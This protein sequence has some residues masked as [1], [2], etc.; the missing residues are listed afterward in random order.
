[1]GSR[2]KKPERGVLFPTDG[3]SR[4]TQKAGKAIL[5]AAI[6]GAGIADASVRDEAEKLASKCEREKNWRFGYVTH[7]INMVKISA[8]SPAAALGVA[9]AGIGAMHERFEFVETEGQPPVPFQQYM[10]APAEPFQTVVIEGTGQVQTELKVPYK[11][12]TLAG[13]A[14]RAQLN[15]WAEYGTIEPDAAR[16]LVDL[17]QGPV[18]LQGQVYVLIGAGSAMGPL[19]ALL[20]HGATVVAVDI[21]GAWGERPQAMWRRLV[22]T[23]RAS[24]GRLV[25]P[26]SGTPRSGSDEEVCALAGCNLIE[27][28]ARILA[29]L[30]G[31]EPGKRLVVG[32]YTYLDGDMHVKLSL[33][34]D[35]IMEGLCAT[36]ADTALAFLCTPTDVHLIP[37]EA[38]RAAKA[39][40]AFTVYTPLELLIRALS[41]GKSLVPNALKP[42]TTSEGGKLP[43][44]DGLSV[45]Q[46]P[47]YALAKRLQHWRAMVAY[48][49]GHT[50]SS[51]IAPSTATLSVVHNKSFAWAYAGMPYF[52]PF[53]IFQ[54]D[55]TNSVM[56]G[57][58]VHDTT[59]PTSAAAPANRNAFGIANPMELFKQ[60]GLHGGV[61]R[62]AYKLDSIG[63]VSVIIHFLGGPKVG[64]AVAYVILMVLALVITAVVQ[65]ML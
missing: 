21:P 50:V 38:R 3:K 16:A 45:A 13:E 43:Y 1:M 5:A 24:G 28:P 22:N 20:S 27:Q 47:N 10:G 58:L 39:N 6:R 52:K 56:A 17:S 61:W 30:R 35:A 51:N 55:T 23:A 46:G 59:V 40:A 31:V 19:T 33:A 14:L 53:E 12:S 2:A 64:M 15:R 44:V 41:L 36:R 42:L 11:G 48:V 34:A 8:R 49:G 18:N 32:N 62:A 4:S 63:E 54:Q 29:W 26:T 37:D 65:T 60:N 7:F 25:I 9:T 57:M